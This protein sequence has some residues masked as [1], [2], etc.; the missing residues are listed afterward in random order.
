MFLVKASIYKTK[1]ALVVVESI[2][3]R[4]NKEFQAVMD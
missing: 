1:G 4:V 2:V 3:S